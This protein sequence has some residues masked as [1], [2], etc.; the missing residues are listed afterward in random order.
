LRSTDIELNAIA[1][2]ATTGVKY[3]K[4]AIGIPT[5]IINKCPE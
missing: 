1:A 3:P 4:A 5:Y 2:A